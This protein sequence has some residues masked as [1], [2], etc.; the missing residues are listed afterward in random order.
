[1]GETKG[2]MTKGPLDGIRILDLTSFIFGPYA[3]Q[4][5]GDL[6]ADVIKIEAPEGD[7]QRSV[8]KAAKN[9]EMGSI[10]MA[11]NRNKRS[12]ALDLKNEADREKLHVLVPDAQVF[13]HNVRGDAAQR[14]GLDYDSIAKLNRSIVYVHCVGYGSDGPYAGRQAFDDLVQAASGAADLLPRVDGNPE[15][16]LFP[17]YVADKVSSLHAVYAVLAALFHR[18]R[19]GEGQCVEV[20]M[21]ESFTS[22]LLVE[23]LA[24]A[25][26]EPHVS[27]M[28]Y[29]PAL[30]ADRKP[31]RTKEGDIIVQSPSRAAS[32]KFLELGRIPN[33][34][35]SERFINAPN[36]KAKVAAYYA[37]LREAA[38]AHTADEWMELGKQHHIPVM[39]ANSLEEVLVDPHLNAVNFFQQRE[40]PSEGPWRAMKPPVKFS[41]TPA[42][43]RRDPP[44]IGENTDELIKE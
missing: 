38:L 35:E 34:Y 29:T 7:R 1:M 9:P 13:I 19:T 21:F 23:H 15:K 26:F 33:A 4:V 18:E 20:P 8:A 42:S 16:R 11:L 6:G 12:V 10:F 17:S 14:L 36:S 2:P 27:H 25:T 31:L 39:R 41:H 40:H 28:G 37:M 3:T 22:F 30:T 5:L 44:R 24:G 43:I 32:A